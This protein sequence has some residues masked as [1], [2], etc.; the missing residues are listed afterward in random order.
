MDQV[1]STLSLEKNALIQAS[2]MLEK[3]TELAET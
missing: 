1:E 3:A 2:E